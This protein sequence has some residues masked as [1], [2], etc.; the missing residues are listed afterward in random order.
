MK[1]VVIFGVPRAG[2]STLANRIADKFHYQMLRVDCIRGAFK[3][4]FPEL[5]IKSWTA[6]DNERFQEFLARYFY[7]NIGQ[8]RNKYNYVLEGC[9]TYVADCDRLFH[10]ENT[11]RYYL[12]M[13]KISPEELVK[14]IRKY[15]SEKD[16]TYKKRDDEILEYAKRCIEQSKINQKE[17]EKYHIKFVD[18][19]L[20]REK[21]LDN[22]MEEIEK[23]IVKEEEK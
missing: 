14:N 9:E 13:T 19:S 18:T 3:D 12:G 23:E 21:V 17:C 5:N 20:N 6:I 22:L 1:N 4:V 7:R 8:S 11:I 15:D 10:D 16:W 2:K